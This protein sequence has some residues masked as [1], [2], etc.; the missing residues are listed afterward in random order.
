[1]NNMSPDNQIKIDSVKK[2]ASKKQSNLVVSSQVQGLYRG[3]QLQKMFAR[4]KLQSIDQLGNTQNL[5]NSTENEQNE[6]S[7]Q[8]VATIADDK[9]EK[10]QT[11]LIETYLKTPNAK[12]HLGMDAID[13]QIELEE[14]EDKLDEEDQLLTN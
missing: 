14:N 6:L 13:E 9:R 8:H 7:G 5:L 3:Q 4:I 12:A 2:E 10:N 11:A 1:M